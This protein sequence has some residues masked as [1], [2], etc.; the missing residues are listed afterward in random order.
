M[1]LKIGCVIQGNIRYG[2]NLVLKEM[3]KHFDEVI[4]STWLDDKDKIVKGDFHILL[5]DKPKN[6]GYSNRNYQRL[7]TSNGIK[8]AE[9]LGC[10]HVLKWRTDMLPT[11]LDIHKLIEY[12]KYNLPIGITA[13]IVT[14]TFRNMT[15][16]PD[17][18]SSIP[19]FFAFSNIEMIKLLW[20]DEEFD[21]SRDFNAPLE[22]F[23]DVGDNWVED[24][25]KFYY[26]ESELYSIFRK[27]LQ[28]KV[29]KKLNHCKIAADYM[30]LINHKKLKICWFSNDYKM[31][32]INKAIYFPWWDEK[33]WLNKKP[34][35][36]DKEYSV[37]G[38]D[39]KIKVFFNYFL[40]LYE[41][42]QQ[43]YWFKSYNKNLNYWSRLINILIILINLKKYTKYFLTYLF[44]RNKL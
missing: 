30:Y 13:R 6:P 27:R 14:C 4:L 18:F 1:N 16:E 20:H 42:S 29:N 7:S 5:N 19:D 8:L 24:A 33:I 10:S 43:E 9:K 41:L 12:S 35:I 31:R 32:T 36:I 37:K 11:N 22:M 21:Y 2:T 26:P 44:K 40:I 28:K 23:I 38:F 34:K 17:W 25:F 3:S 15:V 39:Q